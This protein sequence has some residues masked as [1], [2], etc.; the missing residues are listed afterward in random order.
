MTKQEK[1]T[2]QT[3]RKHMDDGLAAFL[4]ELDRLSDAQMTEP[5]DKAGWNVRDHLT[6]IMAWMDGITA[7][8]QREDRWAAMG[9]QGEPERPLDFDKINAQ[10]VEQHRHLTRAETRARLVDS[11]R[12]IA[13]AM[14]ALAEN[15]LYAPYDRF[16][17]PFTG[18]DGRPIVDYIIG[19]T[20]DHFEEHLMFIRAIIDD[21]RK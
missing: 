16:V 13:A 12:R 15:E 17:P 5:K 7:L 2:K 10:I 11:Y 8:M 18:T 6:H 4:T 20:V 9:L 14:E 19:D 1:Y 3:L 21:E